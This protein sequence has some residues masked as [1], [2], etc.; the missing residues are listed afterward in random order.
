LEKRI[1][2]IENVANCISRSKLSW[3]ALIVIL[4]V[5]VIIS[6]GILYAFREKTISG[7]VV[8]C[9]TNEPVASAEIVVNQSFLEFKGGVIWFKSYISRAMGDPDGHFQVT[10]RIGNSADILARKDGYISARQFEGPGDGVVI[11]MLQGGNPA[12]LTYHCRLLSE[13]LVDSIE[14][15]VRVY[16]NTCVQ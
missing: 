1:N 15:G 5:L 6:L 14:D 4:A 3:A 13:C 2:L 11:K 10:Y 7:S 9:Q 12:E 8:D 16:R